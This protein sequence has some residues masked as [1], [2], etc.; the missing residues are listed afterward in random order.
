MDIKEKQ[1]KLLKKEIR[2]LKRKLKDGIFVEGFKG[3][4]NVLIQKVNDNLIR[5]KIGDCCVY[6]I[7]CIISAEAFGGFLTKVWLD[8]NKPFLDYVKDNLRWE[9]KHNIE[10]MKNCKSLN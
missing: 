8:A 9:G 6:T 7:D 3:G 5:L 1:I 2:D 10:A 4:N